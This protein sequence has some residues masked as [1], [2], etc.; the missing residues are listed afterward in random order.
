GR[1]SGGRVVNLQCVVLRHGIA[2]AHLEIAGIALVTVA[3]PMSQF[4]RG[5]LRRDLPFSVPKYLVETTN[6]AVKMAGAARRRIVR[7][8]LVRSA[9]ELKTAAG[10]PVAA[11]A[12][13]A[14]EIRDV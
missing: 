9:V 14:A 4:Q 3:A 13:D 7:G 10:D 5:S 1:V 11:A 12:D 6:P 8:E 2:Y